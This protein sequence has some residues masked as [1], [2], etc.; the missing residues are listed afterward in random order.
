MSIKDYEYLE[1]TADLFFRSYGKTLGECFGNAA[2]AMFSAMI[3][4][5]SVK[6]AVKKTIRLES[7]DLASLMHDWLSEALFLFETRELVFR[8]FD[9]KI[10]EKKG[11]AGYVLSAV[12]SGE[13]FDRKK[14]L[15]LTDVKA[16]TYHDLKVGERNGLWVADVLCDI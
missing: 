7:S 2:K 6:P 1:H 14:H 13:R 4:R 8:D 11:G 5:A 15:I 10:K 3:E 12:L 16:V 9:V